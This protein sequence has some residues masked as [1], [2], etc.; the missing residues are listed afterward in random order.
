MV[1]LLSKLPRRIASCMGLLAALAL[2]GQ[3]TWARTVPP[4]KTAAADAPDAD[5]VLRRHGRQGLVRMAE[6][7]DRT[8][9]HRGT[10]WGETIGAAPPPPAARS[11]NPLVNFIPDPDGHRF[12]EWSQQTYFDRAKRLAP[13]GDEPGIREKP[14]ITFMKLR[15]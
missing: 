14:A 5:R 4:G 3:S 10:Y 6:S 15:F 12:D 9:D 8:I 2:S 7:R 1:I 13:T 11:R